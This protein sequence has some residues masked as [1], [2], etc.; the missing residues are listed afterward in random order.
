MITQYPLVILA[1]DQ[2]KITFKMF[3]NICY[4]LD[5]CFKVNKNFF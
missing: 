5:V 4:L 2:L 3:F 1:W